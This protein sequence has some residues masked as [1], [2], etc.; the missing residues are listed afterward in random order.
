MITLVTV[1]QDGQEETVKLVSPSET[2]SMQK[3]L[4]F[5]G[6]YSYC[7]R[8]SK[9]RLGEFTGQCRLTFTTKHCNPYSHLLIVHMDDEKKTGLVSVGWQAICI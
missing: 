7:Q 6:F 3:S 1:L 9:E 8:I 5:D 4:K 2:L